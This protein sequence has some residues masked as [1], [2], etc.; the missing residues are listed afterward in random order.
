[1]DVITIPSIHNS[2][3]K[4][5]SSTEMGLVTSPILTEVFYS[6]SQRLP[7]A[8]MVPTITTQSFPSTSSPNYYTIIILQVGAIYCEL[9]TVPLNT[10]EANVNVRNKYMVKTNHLVNRSQLPPRPSVR[11]HALSYLNLQRCVLLQL[12]PY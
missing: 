11:G 10:Q 5:L 9:P 2:F 12:P 3:Q 6:I 8:S 1:M 7:R 4:Y